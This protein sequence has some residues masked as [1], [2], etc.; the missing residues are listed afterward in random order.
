MDIILYVTDQSGKRLE[1]CE[2]SRFDV[3]NTDA[4]DIQNHPG[5]I[6]HG[7]INL[8]PEVE[9]QS[10][11]GIGGAF[12]DA[13]A[14]VWSEMPEDKREE[15]IHAY[16]DRES[17]IGYNLGRLSIASCDFSTEDYTYVEE[18]DMTLDSFDI[19]HDKK[20]VF[21]MI[22]AAGKYSKLKL[23]ASPWSPPA[24]MKTENNRIGGHLKKEC[25]P[26]W[27]KYFAKYID[28][29]RENGVDISAVTVQNEPRHYQI[30]ESCLYTPEEEAEFLGHLGRELNG[31][32]VKILCYD[33]CRERLFERAKYI[34]DGENGKY[35]DGFAHH[36]YSGDHFGE[37]RAYYS[38]Y[39]DKINIMSE[40]CRAIPGSGIHEE[41]NLPHAEIYAHD[42]VGA[43]ANGLTHFC[44]WNLLLNEENG[45][46]HNREGR[47]C[48]AEAPVYYDRK[49]N[50]LIYRLSYYYIGHISKFV[51]RGAKVI[52]S[53]SYDSNIET[54]A[55]KNPDG[56]LVCV[57]LNRTDTCYKPILRIG[58]NIRKVT[59]E[60]HSI[61]TA[62]I[63][64]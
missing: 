61:V 27:A 33:H 6:E 21:P 56:S 28:A 19:S 39:P 49:S 40:G 2:Q 9:Y 17:G 31:K 55:F 48:S 3:K 41:Y 11:G 10:V 46:Y 58:D 29:C 35:C 50:E 23:F 62:I 60:P 25:N 54:V 53:S 13:S 16:F 1:L 57:L 37:L 8:H 51:E 42:M 63:S 26:L 7:V 52:A 5:D 18:G 20:A 24:Y 47:G 12:T 34:F 64:Y 45:P 44:D 30:W 36:W 59:V 38:K 32:G 14:T 4:I 43:F 22:K 15:F